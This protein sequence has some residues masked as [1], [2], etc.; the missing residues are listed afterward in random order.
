[1]STLERGAQFWVFSGP[2]QDCA[3]DL[4]ID[5]GISHAKGARAGIEDL[6]RYIRFSLGLCSGLA[7]DSMAHQT[8]QKRWNNSS[9]CP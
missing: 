6:C 9:L 3:N 2:A 4:V 5:D 1:M 8:S 7:Q